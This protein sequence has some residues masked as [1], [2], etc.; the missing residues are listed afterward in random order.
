M[1][2]VKQ[3]HN[4]DQ[5]WI[6]W[7][8]FLSFAKPV[9][10]AKRLGYFDAARIFSLRGNVFRRR[11]AR[12]YVPVEHRLFLTVREAVVYTGLSERRLRKLIASGC[13]SARRDGYTR[14][15]RR[16]LDALQGN[17]LDA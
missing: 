16:D 2:G 4:S 6:I 15:R 8:F 1:P 9:D 11:A 17:S 7:R 13:L 3:S 14:V 12:P 10:S 5:E